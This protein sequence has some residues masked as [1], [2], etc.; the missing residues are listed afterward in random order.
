MKIIFLGAPGSGKGTQADKTAQYFK[1]PHLSTGDIFR[2]EI[3]KCTELG[4]LADEIINKQGKLVPDEIT[5]KIVKSILLS[6]DYKRGYILDGYP[7]TLNQ[8]QF[9]DNITDIDYVINIEVPENELVK[10]LASRRFCE[11]CK[12]NYNL[13]VDGLRPKNENFC[14]DCGG[15][16]IQREDDKEEVIR[17]RLKI[18]YNLTKPIENFYKRKKILINING[19]LPVPEVFEEIKKILEH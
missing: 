16:L 1:I 2:E 9:L 8:A 11:K 14:D 10:R 19:N 5:N 12:R 15:K 7:R 13:V 17:E 6:D 4:K 3:K 18:Y